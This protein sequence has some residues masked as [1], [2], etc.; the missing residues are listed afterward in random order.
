[1]KVLL[2]KQAAAQ[3]RH[4]WPGLAKESGAELDL[5]LVDGEPVDAEAEV[6]YFAAVDYRNAALMD[7]MLQ[8]ASNGSLKWVHI[9]WV[10]AD[11]PIFAELAQ[12][13]VV[14]SNSAGFNATAIATTV[15]GGI[16]SLS[17]GFHH[18]RFPFAIYFPGTF[19]KFCLCSSKV[20]RRTGSEGVA[21]WP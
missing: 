6:C 12:K 5:V 18:V 16:L 1:M 11:R 19:S 20:A 4:Q 2:S 14:L 10:G 15:I 21:W 9:G 7:S 17:R 8:S 3:L 13:G